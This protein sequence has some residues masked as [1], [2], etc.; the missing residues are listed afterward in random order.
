MIGEA[1]NLDGLV[2]SYGDTIAVDGVDIRALPG[3]FVSVLGP[4]GSGKTS[5]LTMIAGFER[6]SAGRITI[7]GRDITN[8]APNKRNIGM[9]FQ[10]YA[11]FPHLTVRQNIAFPLKLRSKWKSGWKQ[12]ADEMLELVQMGHLADR[13]P[14]EL[15]G[16]QQQRVAVA[17][18]LAFEPPVMLMDEPL[19]ALDKKLREAMQFEI[20]RIQKQVG[21]TVLYVTHDQEEALTMSDRVAIMHAGRVVQIG[22]PAALY[23][24]PY[25]RFVADFI[26][27]MNFLDGKI[28]SVEHDKVLIRLS[29]DVVVRTTASSQ[30]ALTATR[31]GDRICFAMRPERLALKS[32]GSQTLGAIP[33]VIESCV[34]TGSF[35]VFLVRL[36]LPRS[37]V[38]EVQVVT[39]REAEFSVG[40]SVD[41]LPDPEAASCFLEDERRAV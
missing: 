1:L 32:R 5:V 11:L 12:R 14:S 3:E 40:Q 20:K 24:A 2:K 22:T 31:E 8:L 21:A 15:S 23:H 28:L 13:L 35:H 9:V 41:L 10:K 38:V 26:G 29:G 7:S 6:P 34:F 27:K 36:E 30:V 18:A 33:G 37:P 39:G 4:S 19:G 17:R 25:N 16:G